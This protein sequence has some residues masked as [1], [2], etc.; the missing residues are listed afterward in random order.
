M[1]A[2][3]AESHLTGGLLE[4]FVAM[5]LR[6]QIGWSRIRPELAY[7]R[8]RRGDEIDF[9]VEARAGIFDRVKAKSSAT[10]HSGEIAGLL[11]LEEIAGDRLRWG[12]GSSD[13]SPSTPLS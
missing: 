13:L 7:F 12:V 1:S 6:K 3:A 8:T 11:A 2:W 9:V 4:A 5:E 10:V